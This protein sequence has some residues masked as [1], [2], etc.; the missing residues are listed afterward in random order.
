MN[1]L[2]VTWNE[3]DLILNSLCYC[4]VWTIVFLLN[5]FEDKLFQK[6]KKNIGMTIK[7]WHVQIFTFSATWKNNTWECFANNASTEERKHKEAR[8]GSPTE[9]T[10]NEKDGRMQKFY[11]ACACIQ[12][13]LEKEHKKY[14]MDRTL[15]PFRPL[16]PLSPFSPCSPGGPGI[17]TSPWLVMLVAC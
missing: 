15:L 2:T 5:S 6:K 16:S 8:Q 3:N 12:F 14:V 7:F 1:S 11:A 4:H 10:K 17:P 13:T 9:Q